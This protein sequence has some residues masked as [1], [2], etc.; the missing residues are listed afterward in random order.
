MLDDSNGAPEEDDRGV[1]FGVH[2]VLVAEDDP[3]LRRLVVS[4]LLDD[5]HEV[6]EAS[7][8][9]EV[10][11]LVE[12]TQNPS[13]RSFAVDLVIM[14]HRMPG[15]T[16]MEVLER[17]RAH[18]LAVPIILM[19]AFPD[20]WVT[21]QAHQLKAKLLPKPFSLRGLSDSA[22]SLLLGGRRRGRE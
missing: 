14:D 1:M 17:L 9:D 6:Y 20:A 5:G 22:M 7:G 13:G 3:E 2:R 15:M 18:H 19:T 16:G 11:R 10:V 4:R 8:G 21:R 12:R